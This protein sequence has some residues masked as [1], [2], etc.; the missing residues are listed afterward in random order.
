MSD[1][2]IR[3][4]PSINCEHC[5]GEGVYGFGLRCP[6]CVAGRLYPRVVASTQEC[7]SPDVGHATSADLRPAPTV[8]HPVQNHRPVRQSPEAVVLRAYE[9]YCAIHG[10]QPAMVDVPHGCRGG[11]SVGE[12]LA[13]LY[14][15]SFPKDQWAARVD[16]A[17]E[18]NYGE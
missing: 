17:L 6:Y 5:R 7:R 8:F 4:A 18:K 1:P 9:V 2:D 15:R 12:L 14:A 16:E 3:P 11:F 10:A 13:F